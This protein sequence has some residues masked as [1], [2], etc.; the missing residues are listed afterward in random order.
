[1][2]SAEET[3]AR[4]LTVG[5]ALPPNVV[6]QQSLAALLRSLWSAEYSGSRRWHATYAALS[7]RRVGQGGILA[8]N[9]LGEL[10]TGVGCT[11]PKCRS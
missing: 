5:T 4:L 8:L 7:P 11:Q 6:D 9:G 10:A 1:V 2:R 3:F